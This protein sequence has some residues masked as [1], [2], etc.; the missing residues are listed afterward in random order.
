MYMYYQIARV[1]NN[2]LQYAQL[3]YAGRLYNLIPSKK[4]F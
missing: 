1:F 3:N 2:L 4:I